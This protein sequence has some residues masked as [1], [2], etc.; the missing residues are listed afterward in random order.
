MA[1]PRRPEPTADTVTTAIG[2]L[3][4]PGP[5]DLVGTI[6][7]AVL[8]AL[9]PEAHLH[10]KGQTR[11]AALISAAAA[12]AQLVVETHSDHVLNG[13]RLAVKRGDLQPSHA[14][15]RRWVGAAG[16]PVV[17]VVVRR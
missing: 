10:P 2:I 5:A 12:G 15:R 13:V 14:G 9:N 17:L 4:P 6:G 16:E 11:M 1:Y 7:G 3:P 8:D